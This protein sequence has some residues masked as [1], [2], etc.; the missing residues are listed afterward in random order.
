MFRAFN[1]GVGL[2]VACAAD[3]SDTVLSTLRSAGETGATVVG[4]VVPGD[5]SVRYTR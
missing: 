5:G 4:E 2:I 3:D 1:M